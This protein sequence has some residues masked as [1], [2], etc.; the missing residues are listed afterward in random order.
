[1]GITEKI[2]GTYE[3]EN[4]SLIELVSNELNK[5]GIPPTDSNII[6]YLK[7]LK[8]SDILIILGL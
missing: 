5:R 2:T 4:N 6:Y 3:S 8:L 1:M 7:S